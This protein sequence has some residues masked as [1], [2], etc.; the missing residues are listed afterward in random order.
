MR[1][2]P[3]WAGAGGGAQA[4]D[5]GP[6]GSLRVADHV[7]GAEDEEEETAL[8]PVDLLHVEDLVLGAGREDEE[9]DADLRLVDCCCCC[10]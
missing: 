8:R 7:L 4:G 1:G 6:G 9:D 3:S 2:L 5:P 10:C